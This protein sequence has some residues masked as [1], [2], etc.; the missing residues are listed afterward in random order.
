[1]E[2]GH[3]ANSSPFPAD[4]H[5][6]SRCPDSINTYFFGSFLDDDPSQ[7]QA[8]NIGS[9][10]PY[11]MNTTPSNADALRRSSQISFTIH[12]TSSPS[13]GPLT[14]L[15]S[16]APSLTI[17]NT[18]AFPTGNNSN[19]NSCPNTTPFA[20]DNAL[21]PR[22]TAI[23][24]DSRSCNTQLT[25]SFTHPGPPSNPSTPHHLQAQDPH[26]TYPKC[27][28]STTASAPEPDFTTFEWPDLPSLLKSTAEGDNMIWKG[29]GNGSGSGTPG[30]STRTTFTLEDANPDVI[31]GVMKV[32]VRSNTKVRFE[33]D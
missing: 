8:G 27:P 7:P 16:Q 12:S 2:T 23:S 10:S 32:L 29:G 28:V 26:Y 14:R 6:S 19:S 4:D 1:M 11:Q 20:A 18:M 3:F 15:G 17:L 30:K 13:S 21:M 24:S 31:M 33:T 25:T 9:S 5:E 22:N